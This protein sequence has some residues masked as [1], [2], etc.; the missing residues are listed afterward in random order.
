MASSKRHKSRRAKRGTHVS[1][2]CISP[3]NYRSSWELK[4]ALYLD[5]NVDVV[6]YMYE[7]YA[8][9]YVSNIK[10][11]KI[12]RYLPDFEIIWKNGSKTLV[13]IKPVKKVNQIKNVKKAIAAK[14]FAATN[15]L[16]YV[17]ITEVDLK[18]LELL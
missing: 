5:T 11:G 8:I 14:I 3:F 18:N 12:R 16:D 7:P 6:S 4:Y 1:L 17:L 2:K 10:T 9:D 15:G 13:E